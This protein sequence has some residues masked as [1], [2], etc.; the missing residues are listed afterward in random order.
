MRSSIIGAAALSV[1]AF[2][3]FWLLFDPNMLGQERTLLFGAGGAVFAGTGIGLLAVA[4][5]RRPVIVVGAS[6]LVV[7]VALGVITASDLRT[8]RGNK[9]AVIAL[10]IAAA[11]GAGATAALIV[12]PA[13]RRSQGAM[14]PV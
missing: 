4:G 2:V 8:D 12:G 13:R 14:P 11:S 10:M 1:A 9:K 5:G 7:A 3:A 6:L